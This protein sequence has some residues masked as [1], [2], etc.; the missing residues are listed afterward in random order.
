M[1]LTNTPQDVI[2]PIEYHAFKENYQARVHLTAALNEIS[3]GKLKKGFEKLKKIEELCENKEDVAAWFFFMGLCFKM[4]GETGLMVQHFDMAE[5]AGHKFYLPYLETAKAAHGDAAFDAAEASYK[6]AIAC[7]DE[8]EN[9]KFFGVHSKN[10]VLASALTNFASCLTMMHHYD[11]AKEALERAEA[12]LPAQTGRSATKA[13]LCAAMKD[14]EGVNA[15]LEALKTEAPL[16]LAQAKQM[17]DEILAGKNAQFGIVDP[18]DGGIEAF[19]A[20]F[21]ENEEKLFSA[22]ESGET[23]GFFEAVQPELAKPFAFLKRTPELGIELKDGKVEAVLADF[24]SVSLAWGY[25]K[26]IESCP[27]KIKARWSFEI[28]R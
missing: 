1:G 23:D 10:T 8:S 9:D 28:V 2:I 15:C 18:V 25:T 26:L 20:W 3:G 4:A 17:T 24:Y 5:Q 22:V 21:S 13:I 7:L 12:L 6:K 16:M 27:E 19:W 11:E 14:E